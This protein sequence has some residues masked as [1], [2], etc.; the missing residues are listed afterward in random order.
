MT[1]QELLKKLEELEGGDPEGG[2]L[3]ADHLL[4]EYIDDEK[5]KAAFEAISKWYA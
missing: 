4:L 5:I 3:D 1:K 2:H